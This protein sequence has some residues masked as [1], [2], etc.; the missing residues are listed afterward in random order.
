MHSEG[1]LSLVYRALIDAPEALTPA[2]TKMRTPQEYMAALLRLAGT[3]PKGEATAAALKAMG[4]P[5]WTPGGP[6]GFSDLSTVW[7]SPEALSTRIEVANLAAEKLGSD[8]DARDL[9]AARMGPALSETTKTAIAR[10][11][12]RA[13][14]LAIGL[15]SPEFMRR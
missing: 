15:L 11:E 6:N 4:Q 2:R 8:L 13:Q 1:D 3:R 9:F 12:S 5:L 7:T 10:A 14:G